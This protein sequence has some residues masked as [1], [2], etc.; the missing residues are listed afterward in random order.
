MK[1]EEAAKF[2][3]KNRKIIENNKSAGCYYC[4]ETFESIKIKSYTDGGSTALCPFCGIDCVIGGEFNKEDLS[5]IKKY[6][7]T[8]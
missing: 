5:K 1:I 2:S 4:L 6:W 7:L 3:F 8:V